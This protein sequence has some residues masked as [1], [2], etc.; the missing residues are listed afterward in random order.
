M[1]SD[2]RTRLLQA[3]SESEGE[4]LSGQK[5]SETLGC[6]RTAVWKHIEDLRSEGYELEAVRKL[7]YRI[8]HKP[9]KIS[10][11]EIQLGL[12]TKFMG[13]HI[14][15]EEVVPS[16]Q[17]IAHSLAG[18]GAEEGTIVVADQQTSGRGRLARV[19]YSPKQTG[20]WMSLILRPKI[21]IN[22]TPQLTLLT[23]VAL[24]QSIEEVTGLTPEIK[25]PNDI[26]INGKKIVGILT[27]LQAEADQVH[28]VII[29]IG[30]NVNHALDQFPEELQSVATSIAIE[31]GKPSDRAEV[32]QAILKNFEKL[33]TSYL[34]HGFKPVKL[35]WESYAISLNKNLIARTLHGAIRGRAAGIDDEG[36]LLLETA[37]GKIEKIYSADI[38]IQP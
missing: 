10:G 1:Q 13:R 21:P 15:F 33:Y 27:E 37:E 26:L 19:W 16:T 18:N 22:K 3:F 8:T 23:A 35:L 12:K 34:I 9:D 20:I 6:S 17:K 24:I 38:E 14:H 30:M 29:G 2:L 4:F 36:V 11:N 32:I 28:S 31:T 5:L 7:G 25:W